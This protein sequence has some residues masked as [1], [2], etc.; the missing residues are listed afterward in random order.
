MDTTF[1]KGVASHPIHLPWISPCKAGYCFLKVWVLSPM[2]SMYVQGHIYY[3]YLK[4]TTFIELNCTDQHS[5]LPGLQSLAESSGRKPVASYCLLYSISLI[6]MGIV[7][8]LFHALFKHESY[9]YDLKINLI[10]PR[11][12]YQRAIR[13]PLPESCPL[14]RTFEHCMRCESKTGDALPPNF[15][16]VN[17]IPAYHDA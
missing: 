11:S 2:P 10:S 15:L 12:H 14:L 4:R 6:D 16:T 9:C 7:G 1:P 5:Q 17:S 8:M 3:R 13:P